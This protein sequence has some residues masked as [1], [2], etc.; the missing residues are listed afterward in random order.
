MYLLDTMVISETSKANPEL[1]VLAWL[2]EAPLEYLYTSALCWGEV[3]F[4][5]ERLAPGQR[6]SAMRNW[7][8]HEIAAM[9]GARVLHFDGEI[10]LIWGEL[11][12]Q[13]RRTMPMLDTLIAATALAH[14]LTIVT[15]NIADFEGLGVT[16]IN[17]WSNDQTT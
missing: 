15:R 8:H 6:R 4:G 3:Q 10:A 9:F 14:G 17:P 2:N 5:I 11:R 13:A 16:L 1:A 12:A 7:F